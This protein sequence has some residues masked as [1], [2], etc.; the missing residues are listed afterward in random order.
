LIYHF[1]SL[2]SP[3]RR[4][5]EHGPS[6]GVQTANAATDTSTDPMSGLVQKIADKFNLNKDEVQAVFDAQRT[7]ME[8]ERTQEMKDRLAQAVK[9]GKLTQDQADKITAKLA[10]MKANREDLSGKTPE[11]RHEAMKA[12]RDEIKKWAED[13]NIPMEYLR[14]VGGGHGGL[15]LRQSSESANQ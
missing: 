9:D 10:E 11:E 6:L 5:L 4:N 8:A 12:A 13:N 2:L 14:I 1:L 15:H 7:E 3:S